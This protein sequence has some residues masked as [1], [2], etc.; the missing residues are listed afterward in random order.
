[1][2]LNGPELWSDEL[3]WPDRSDHKH[4][5]GRL[6]VISGP[7]GATGAARL[8]ALSGQR[9]GAGVVTLIAERDAMAELAASNLSV[10]TKNYKDVDDLIERSSQADAIVLGPAAGLGGQTRQNVLLLLRHE[11]KLVLD[12]DALS[13]FVDDPRS[14]TDALHKDVILTPHEGEFKRVFPTILEREANRLDA[15]RKAAEIAGCTVILKGADTVIGAPDG[16]VRVNVHASPFLA[17][18][19]SGDVLTGIAG[20]LMAMGLAPF[21]CSKRCGLDAWRC[22]LTPWS[23]LIA[24]DLI[25]ALPE[26]L[27]DLLP[28]RP[29]GRATWIRKVIRTT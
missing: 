4:K 29:P 17:T 11:R 12:A 5:R 7:A 24:E 23:G 16:R 27:S 8:A 6:Q 20:G 28:V 25:A 15:V 10:M 14:L 19:G 22:I 1:M 26:V 2:R 21:R 13:V 18:A 3:V 9:A